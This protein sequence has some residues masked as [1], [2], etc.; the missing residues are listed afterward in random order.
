MQFNQTNNGNGI[1][2][3]SRTV[4]APNVDMI[5]RGGERPIRRLIKR[6]LRP[7]GAWAAPESH[8]QSRM[9]LVDFY[10]LTDPRQQDRWDRSCQESLKAARGDVGRCRD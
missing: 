4:T 8:H 6:S 5:L 10:R 3:N 9:T 2:T 7:A 1:F